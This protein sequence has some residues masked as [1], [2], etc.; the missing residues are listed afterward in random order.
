M[1]EKTGPAFAGFEDAI[2]SKARERGESLEARKDKGKDS[3]LELQEKAT[4]TP[5]F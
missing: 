4:A 5:S 3:P 1:S 2:E